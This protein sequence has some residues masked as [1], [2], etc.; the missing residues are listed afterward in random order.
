M[1]IIRLKALHKVL[2]SKQLEVNAKLP[3][4]HDEDQWMR[5]YLTCMNEIL[6]HVEEIKVI[7]GVLEIS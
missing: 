2:I 3:L 1:K 4:S 5:G 6:P 7:N